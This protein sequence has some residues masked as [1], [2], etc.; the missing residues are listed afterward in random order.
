LAHPAPTKRIFLEI[1]I[2]GNLASFF[3]TLGRL[4]ELAGYHGQVDIG[5]AVTGAAGAQSMIRARAGGYFFTRP[6]GADVYR[7]TTRV[8]AH[9]LAEPKPIVHDL[10]R[11]LFRSSTGEPEFDPFA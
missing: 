5:A 10:L 9:Q 8:A 11:R 4:Y 2:A 6:Y 1:V 7:R 3:A